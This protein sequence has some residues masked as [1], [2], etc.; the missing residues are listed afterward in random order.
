MGNVRCIVCEWPATEHVWVRPVAGGR[1]VALY[2]CDD[3]CKTQKL[4]VVLAKGW[5]VS[6]GP[7]GWDVFVDLDESDELPAELR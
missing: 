3:D 7:L 6:G 1:R 2:F 4:A 5:A